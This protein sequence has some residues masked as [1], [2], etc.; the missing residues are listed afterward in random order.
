MT[1]YQSFLSMREEIMK[2]KWIESEK[3]NYDIG[4][5]YALVDWIQKHRAGWLHSKGL[6]KSSDSGKLLQDNKL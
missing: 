3:L 5:D 4:F 1:L 2:H 6:D